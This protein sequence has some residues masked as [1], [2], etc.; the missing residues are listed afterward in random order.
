MSGKI[1]ASAIGFLLDYIF[2]F[3]GIIFFTLILDV[4]GIFDK[5]SSFYAKRSYRNLS[6]AI[7]R[8]KSKKHYIEQLEKDRYERMPFTT[9]ISRCFRREKINESEV[10]IEEVENQFS[11][12]KKTRKVNSNEIENKK[13]K[14]SF[15]KKENLSEYYFTE[16]LNISYLGTRAY[17]RNAASEK[18]SMCGFFYLHFSRGFLVSC[19]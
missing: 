11:E 8:S 10:D 1:H 17:R 5:I 6:E 16:L 13:G 9:K 14:C 18:I 7:H 19:K 2:F 12:W 4:C 15:H 3:F